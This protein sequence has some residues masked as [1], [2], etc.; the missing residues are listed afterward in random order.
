MIACYV[1][2]F[3]HSGNSEFDRDVMTKLKYVGFQISL[4][5]DD[6]ITL[7]QSDFINSIETKS[8]SAEKMSQKTDSVNPEE[9]SQFR[10]I[11]MLVK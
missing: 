2:G 1:D 4:D 8:L 5:N 7:D 6:G 11:V 10:H 3:L 9:Q